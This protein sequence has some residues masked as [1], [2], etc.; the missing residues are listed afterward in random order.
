M[1]SLSYNRK[2]AHKRLIS[3]KRKHLGLYF[4]W[5]IRPVARLIES[6]VHMKNMWANGHNA[7]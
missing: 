4:I 2:E 6:G 7:F 3:E 1:Y 5:D